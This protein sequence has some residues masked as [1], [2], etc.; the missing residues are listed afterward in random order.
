MQHNTDSI[1]VTIFILQLDKN[2]TQTL[3]HVK[4][5][6]KSIIAKKCF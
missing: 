3:E 1:Y 6:Y 5:M 4:Y 2:N